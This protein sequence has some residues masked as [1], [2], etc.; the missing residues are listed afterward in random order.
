QVVDLMGSGVC[1]FYCNGD[2]V[3]AH[4]CIISFLLKMGMIRKTKTG[5]LYNISFKYDS[6]T[7]SNKYGAEF[8]SNIKLNSFLNLETGEW[9]K[10]IQLNRNA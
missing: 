4:K 1:C 8:D 3:E 5:K 7:Q 2:D 6:Q 9:L 10:T